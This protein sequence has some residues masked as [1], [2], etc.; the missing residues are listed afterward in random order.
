MFRFVFRAF[1]LS[2]L[3]FGCTSNNPQSGENLFVPDPDTPYGSSEV[4][5]VSYALKIPTDIVS[6]FEETG[7]GFD[8]YVTCPLEKIPLYD[9]PEHVALLLGVLGVDLCYNTLF[10]MKA[11]MGEY[12]THIELL[13]NK[14][15]LPDETFQTSHE[16]RRALLEN[17]D[18]LN[19][20]ISKIYTDMENHLT[21]TDQSSLAALSLL[22]GWIETMYI[23]ISIYKD[24]G[25]LEMGDR[26]L[27]QKYSL[28]TLSAMLA[29]QQESLMIR[30]YMHNVNKLKEVY[31]QVE[32][33]YESESFIMDNEENAFLA[34]V[35]EISYEPE[36]LEKICRIILQLRGDILPLVN[37]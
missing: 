34:S 33:R 32:I 37:R 31:D 29:N 8:P 6:F 30:R 36:S 15:D 4:M 21:E 22:G 25:V 23:G 16:Q 35:A 24:K 7:T 5:E 1:I 26:I 18:S 13:A 17:P 9:N 12:Y 20:H 2:L 14:L 3:V 10:E 11:E 28:N 27:Q 19:Q